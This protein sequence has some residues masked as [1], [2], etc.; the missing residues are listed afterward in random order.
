[1]WWGRDIVS[2]NVGSGGGERGQSFKSREDE[3]KNKR[4]KDQKKGGRKRKIHEKSILP[5]LF[6]AHAS[7]GQE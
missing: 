1:M 5:L 3:V 4:K 7:F 2:G 6:L